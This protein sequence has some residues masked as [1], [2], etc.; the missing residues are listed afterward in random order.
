MTTKIPVGFVFNKALYGSESFYIHEADWD[1]NC[2]QTVTNS[3]TIRCP[4]E[5]FA[6]KD[7][8]AFKVED[9][10]LSPKNHLARI[11][12]EPKKVIASGGLNRF[13]HFSSDWKTIDKRYKKDE[14]FGKRLRNHK[15]FKKN[16]PDSI[17]RIENTLSRAK[18][19]YYLIQ[20]H[21]DW[22][23]Y[24]YSYGST[25]EDVYDKKQGSAAEINVS[26][27]NALQVAG[28][29]AKLMM[30]STRENGLPTTL[31]PIFTKFNYTVVH[32]QIDDKVYLLDATEK[33]APFG[34]L[35]FYALNVQG[36][37]MDF[38]K[39]SSWQPLT[40]YTNNVYYS[41][42]TF[43]VQ[44]DGSFKGKSNYSSS[45]YIALERRKNLKKLGETEYIQEV[46]DNIKDAGTVTNHIITKTTDVE[47]PY[48]EE[49]QFTF[50]PE[51]HNSK[52]FLKSFP[53]I[54][55]IGTNPFTSE[56]RKYPIDIGYPFSIIYQNTIDLGGYYEIV[57]LPESV[58][59]N[60]PGNDG[61]C[62]IAY[63]LNDSVLDISFHFRLNE[64][65]FQ[66]NTYSSLS[67]F[68][69]YAIDVIAQAF[70]EIKRAD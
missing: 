67:H 62:V 40:P 29:D 51:A 4:I 65:R 53:I 27:I 42:S 22:N 43:V 10:M 23:G 37:V 52:L 44:P 26:L 28:L 15:H 11:E 25:L 41:K 3:M 38:K 34:L 61:Q 50:N 58:V 57:E 68:F 56:E 21:Y 8:P 63:T 49:Y 12:F 66:P 16:I 54:H 64:Y 60:L 2:I 47:S 14:L 7:I 39:K 18:A 20:S 30:I 19:V 6:M 46:A 45:G 33:E 13:H 9:F 24:F 55:Y 35:P 17:L 1:G 31:H 59:I 69:E 32:L 70:I 48:E 5:L 36:R